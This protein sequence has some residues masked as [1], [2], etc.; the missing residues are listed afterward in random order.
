MVVLC[1]GCPL[2]SLNTVEPSGLSS[3]GFNPVLEGF[4]LFGPLGARARITFVAMLLSNKKSSSA[5]AKEFYNEG[6]RFCTLS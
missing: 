1:S 4:Q 3:F 6:V 2:P 5:G